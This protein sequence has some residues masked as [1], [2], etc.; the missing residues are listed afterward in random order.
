MFGNNRNELRQDYLNCWQLKKNNLPMDQDIIVSTTLSKADNLKAMNKLISLDEPP[1][2]VIVFNDYVLLD[3]MTAV[4]TAG[5]QVNKDISFISFAN[6]PIWEYMDS[7]P[8]ASTEQFAYKQSSMAAEFLFRLIN[9][10][11]SANP[12]EMP[13]LQHIIDSEM[14][15]YSRS[16]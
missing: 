16:K 13:L 9:N 2:A 3:C 12:I 14:V 10:A 1:T 4:K 5:L 15:E 8:L 11:T 7:V 6:L